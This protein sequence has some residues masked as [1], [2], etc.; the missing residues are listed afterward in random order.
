MFIPS[1]RLGAAPADFKTLDVGKD[2]GIFLHNDSAKKC[3]LMLALLQDPHPPTAHGFFQKVA[4]LSS[5]DVMRVYVLVKDTVIL[6]QNKY[7]RRRGWGPQVYN[8]AV[9]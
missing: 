6:M 9:R 4:L 2:L 5:L 3:G 8:L 7:S 1:S